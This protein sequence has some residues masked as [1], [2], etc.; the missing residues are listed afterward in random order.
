MSRSSV[1]SLVPSCSTASGFVSQP[2]NPSIFHLLHNIAST[3][4]QKLAP[5]GKL[6]MEPNIQKRNGG[7]HRAREEFLDG[8]RGGLV[9]LLR[10]RLLVLAT[11]EEFARKAKL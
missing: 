3:S 11:M 4:R 1:R 5:V 2:A 10:I 8:E 9:H 7:K 6:S